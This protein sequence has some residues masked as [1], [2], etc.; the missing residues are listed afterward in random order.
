[1]TS[2]PRIVDSALEGRAIINLRDK[3]KEKK[4]KMDELY[5]FTLLLVRNVIFLFDNLRKRQLTPTSSKIL[6]V[7]LRNLV[8][9]N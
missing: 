4:L 6:E 7:R 5:Y 8:K 2:I 9:C 1:M 3:K